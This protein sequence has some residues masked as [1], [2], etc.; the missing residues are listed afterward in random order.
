MK[1]FSPVAWTRDFDHI[2]HTLTLGFPKSKLDAW[3]YIF[4]RQHYLKRGTSL[5][6]FVLLYIT[7]PKS[8]YGFVS[9]YTQS[10]CIS[11]VASLRQLVSY[12]IQLL[13]RNCWM[14][15]MDYTNSVTCLFNDMRYILC[16]NNNIPCN[17]YMSVWS[18]FTSISVYKHWPDTREFITQTVELWNKWIRLSCYNTRVYNTCPLYTHVT[19]ILQCIVVYVIYSGVSGQSSHTIGYFNVGTLC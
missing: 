16:Y 3:E 15:Y 5:F 19:P 10:V 11:I 17:E 8:N 9:V 14:N 12:C 2:M 13:T 4:T 7:I 1:I 6:K 18:M